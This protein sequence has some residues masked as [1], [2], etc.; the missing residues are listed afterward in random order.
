MNIIK[1][2]KLQTLNRSRYL[3]IVKQSKEKQRM[4][5]SEIKTRHFEWHIKCY[6]QS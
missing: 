5:P 2:F 1:H 4:C 3:T 6:K